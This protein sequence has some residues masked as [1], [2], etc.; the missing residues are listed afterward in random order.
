MNYCWRKY[1]THL[2]PRLLAK[3]NTLLDRGRQ[4]MGEL[5]FVM[6]QRVMACRDGHF[7]ARLQVSELAELANAHYHSVVGDIGVGEQ[8]AQLAMGDTPN[9]ASGV[10]GLT[11][12]DTVAI[13]EATARLLSPVCDWFTEGFD[14]AD[15]Q[16][17]KTLLNELRA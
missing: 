9:I 1:S 15:L 13:S 17:A 2:L 10:Q 14:T 11:V 7:E 12:S 16:E 8:Q 6:S 5:G 4:V 3:R